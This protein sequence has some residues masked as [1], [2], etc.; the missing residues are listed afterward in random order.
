MTSRILKLLSLLALCAAMPSAASAITLL[1]ATAGYTV[2]GP[3]QPGNVDLESI[4]SNWGFENN[5][6]ATYTLDQGTLVLRRA[7]IVQGNDF[8][9]TFQHKTPESLSR[10]DDYLAVYGVDGH[11]GHHARAGSAA[12]TLN[13]AANTFSFLWGSVDKS[14]WISVE[15]AAGQTYE[16]TGADVL[17]SVAGIP[18]AP[19]AY[20]GRSTQYFSLT[21]VAG[22]LK[23]IF[24][25]C[26]QT[27]E[28]ANINVSAVPLPAALPLFAAGLFGLAGARRLRKKA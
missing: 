13:S 15:N 2:G 9:G 12:F 24:H 5:Y 1:P 28:V 21:D 27:F 18:G 14:N 23:V 7:E 19:K 20:E 22:I 16:I 26:R 10:Y 25:A 17:A 4:D 8:H 11:H 3:A 6:H